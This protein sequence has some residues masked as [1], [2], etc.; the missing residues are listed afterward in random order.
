MAQ[1]RQFNVPE[2]GVPNSNVRLPPVST[3]TIIQVLL[4]SPESK[5]PGLVLETLVLGFAAQVPEGQISLI[6][7]YPLGSMANAALEQTLAATAQSP[8]VVGPPDGQVSEKV[9]LDAAVDVASMT[10]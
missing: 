9:M 6:A 3:L 4:S 5:H 2:L 10:K 1:S 7:P 8:A